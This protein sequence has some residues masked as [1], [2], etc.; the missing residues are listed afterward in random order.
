MIFKNVEILN[1]MLGFSL[2]IKQ[3]FLYFSVIVNKVSL[4]GR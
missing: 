2:F 1:T 4:V 3:V